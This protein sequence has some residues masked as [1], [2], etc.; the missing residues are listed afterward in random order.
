MKNFAAMR[1][2]A[3]A[4]VIGF[5]A[6]GQASTVVPVTEVFGHNEGTNYSGTIGD[7][8][9][10]SGMNGYGLDGSPTWPSGEG[11]PSTWSVTSDFYGAEWQSRAL[12]SD[13]SN[14]K[15]GWAVFD[16]GEITAGLDELYIWHIREN[17]N[18]VA[19]LFNVYTA[20]APSVSVSHGPTSGFLDYDF[21][22]GG[23]TTIATGQTGTFRGTSTI[24]LGG[25]DARYVAL[26]VLSNGGDTTRTGFAEVGI[27]AVPEPAPALLGS[28]GLLLLLRFRR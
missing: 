18:R 9:N 23:W 8:S 6:T 26:E 1:C 19:T 12:V 15:I 13:G 7:M 20:S 25:V 14:G 21:A 4:L 22:S 16:L 5:A 10:G 17:T 3:A 24:S 27:T 28:L 11:L 2:S